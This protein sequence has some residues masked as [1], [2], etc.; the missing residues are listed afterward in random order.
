MLRR[1]AEISVVTGDYTVAS[2]YLNILSRTRNHKEWAQNLLDCIEADSIPEQY[3]VWRTRTATEDRFFPQGDI[4]TSLYIIAQESPYNIVAKDYLL[5]SYLL[6]KNVNTFINLYDRFYL[7]TLDQIITVPDLYQEA[8]LVNVNSNESLEET[9][10]KYHISDRIV[11]KFMNQMIVRSQSEDP[12][13]ITEEAAGTYWNY[14]M[15]VSLI[16]RD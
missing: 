6:D 16:K 10:R 15:A 1:L 3:M 5:C 7:N 4:R 13:V 11:E 2:K 8:L 14:I 12:N 9:V